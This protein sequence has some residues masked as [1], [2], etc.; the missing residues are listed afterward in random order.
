MD[1]IVVIAITICIIL[2]VGYL[3]LFT[4]KRKQIT[5]KAFTFIKN[6]NYSDLDNLCKKKSANFF[7]KPFELYR[8]KLISAASKGD[9]KEIANR[10]KAFDSLRMSKKEK[11]NIYSDAY[12]WFVSKNNMEE[13]KKYYL[14]LEEIGDYNNK[15]S[16]QCSYNTFVE[17]GYKYLDDAIIRYNMA[18]DALKVSLASLISSMYLNK[19]DKENATKYDNLTKDIIN[20]LKKQ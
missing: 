13:A 7:L 16:I 11:E 4:Y 18:N 5:N 19:G 12:F 17:H 3:I 6:K 10:Y 1:N 20:K 9:D 8:I 15:F 2:T 14:L